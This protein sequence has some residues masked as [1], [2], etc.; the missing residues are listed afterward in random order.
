MRIFGSVFDFSGTDNQ[1]DVP[2]VMIFKN[3]FVCEQNG[4]IF[5]PSLHWYMFKGKRKY[6]KFYLFIF[7]V[8]SRRLE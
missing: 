3:V 5:F 6:D 1:I 4:F 8:P 7:H 2:I